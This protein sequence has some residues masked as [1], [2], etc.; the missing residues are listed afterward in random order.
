MPAPKI[1]PAVAADLAAVLALYRQLHPDD[2]LPDEAAAQAAWS[3]LLASDL[4]T[5]FVAELEGRAVS[6]CTL[7]LVPNLSRGAR[8]YGVIE[9]V[10]TDAARRRQGLARAV[11]EAAIERAAQADCHKV[12]LATGSRTEATL[13]FYEGVGFMRDAKTYFEIRRP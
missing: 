10:V 13:R 3:A 2:P 8:P 7:A 12:F 1:R 6:S 9:N 5:T 11:L 4:T